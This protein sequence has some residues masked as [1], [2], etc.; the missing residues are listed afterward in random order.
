MADQDIV[1]GVDGTGDGDAALMWA[2]DEA[3]RARARLVVVH[4]WEAGPGGFAPY[5]RPMTRAVKDRRAEQAEQV[6]ERALLRVRAARPDVEVTG[7]TV[8]GRP[9]TALRHAARGAALLVLGS[10]A[11][12]AGDGRLGAVLLACLRWPPCPVVVV[13]DG[14]TVTRRPLAAAAAC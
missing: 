8:E 13:G 9:E 1:V 5:A 12:R 10:A 7:R 6:L 14:Q 4:A 3:G 2:A 11:H